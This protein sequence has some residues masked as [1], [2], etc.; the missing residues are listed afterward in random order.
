MGIQIQQVDTR[1]APESLLA[2]MHEYYGL[3]RAEELPDDPLVPFERQVADWRNYREDESI[4]RWLLRVDG[5]I[6]AVAVAFISLDQN[7]DNAFARVHVRPELRRQGLGRRLAQ[8]VLEFLSNGGRKR[9]ST[10]ILEGNLE[11]DLL[12][13]LGLKS[14]YRE[15]RSRLVVA[16]IDM[17]LMKS[18]IDRASERAWEYELLYLE[19]PFPDDVVDKYCELQFQMNTAPFEDFEQ[20]D[21]VLT[22][23]MWR[24]NEEKMTLSQHEIHTFVAIHKASGEFVGS[25]TLNTDKLQP[26]QAW[27]WETV[28]HPDHRNRGLGR[29]LK[30]AN[31]VKVVEERPL[32][33]R[34]DT[35][36]AGSNEPMLNINIEMGFKQLL[37]TD[38]WQGDLETARERLGV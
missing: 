14:V 23:E 35:W 29:W 8:P 18:W 25:T 5:E 31:I 11:G 28:V 10:Y 20:D 12:K 1:S 4:P 34:I 6:A 7:L 9:L 15:R 17:V 37:V 19:M 33:D 21:E 26:D 36:N 32:M 27:Q 13:K 3:V 2:E 22:S 24:D 38:Q 30:A 16:D